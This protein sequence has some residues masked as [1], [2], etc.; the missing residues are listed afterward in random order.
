MVMNFLLGDSLSPAEEE[1]KFRDDTQ[2]VTNLLAAFVES[3]DTLI[4]EVLSEGGWR[5][6]VGK[7]KSETDSNT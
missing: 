2:N 7:D 3:A 5:M 6:R 4:G 1:S